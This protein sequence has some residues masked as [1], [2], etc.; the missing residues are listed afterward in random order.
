MLR[1]L[2]NY[3]IPGFWLFY[4]HFHCSFWQFSYSY[5]YP[6]LLGFF[7]LFT[8]APFLSHHSRVF[9]WRAT[10][11]ISP[12]LFYAIAAKRE[13]LKNIQCCAANRVH[14][15]WK[16]PKSELRKTLNN[17][18]FSVANSIHPLASQSLQ[19]LQNLKNLQP[20]SPPLFCNRCWEQ[21]ILKNINCCVVIRVDPIEN[22]IQCIQIIEVP[23][24]QCT[25]CKASVL[26]TLLVTLWD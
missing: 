26:V 9:I 3:E 17:M 13:T 21:V 2:Q 6:Q 8:T 25:P 20:I 16:W 19:H 12:P 1:L 23:G 7:T 22:K 10:S 24:A 4:Y 5:H 11:S 18:N 15:C 14:P